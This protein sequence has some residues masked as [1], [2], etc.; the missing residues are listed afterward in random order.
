MA[1]PCLTVP[2]PPGE[3]GVGA[4]SGEADTYTNCCCMTGYKEYM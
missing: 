3:V 1:R 4:E 2:P